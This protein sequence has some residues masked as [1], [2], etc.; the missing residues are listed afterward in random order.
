MLRHKSRWLNLG[1]IIT[2]L[3]PG[4]GSFPARGLAAPA[5]YANRA[6]VMPSPVAPLPPT[7]MPP[8][9]LMPAPARP[10]PLP[11][12]TSILSP[13]IEVAR[14]QAE[15]ET[16]LQKYLDYLGPRYV[17]GPLTVTVD[18]DWALGVAAWRSDAKA[19]GATLQIIGHRQPGGTWQVALP[20]DGEIYNQW[21]LSSTLM[22]LTVPVSETPESI[23]TTLTSPCHTNIPPAPTSWINTPALFSHSAYT[24][25]SDLPLNALPQPTTWIS[26]ETSISQLSVAERRGLLGVPAAVIEWEQAQA[27]SNQ[28]IV[29]RVN[30]YPPAKDWRN[31]NGQDW[32]TPIRSQ[33]GCGSCVAFAT[34]GAIES[35][36]KIAN[37]NSGLNPDLSEAHLFFCNGRQCNLGEPNYGWSPNAALDF[38]RDTGIVDEPC[39]PYTD[40]N[41]SCNLCTDWSNR[42][43]RI[44]SWTGTS[45][46]G[47]MKQALAD[48]GPFE[49][50]MTVYQDFYSY[51]GGIYR[52]T[53]G[54]MEGGHAVTVVGYDESGGYWIVKN[55]W[56]TNWGENGWFRIAYGECGIDDYNYIPYV[57]STPPTDQW[58]VDYFNQ[59]GL[60]FHLQTDYESTMFLNHDWGNGNPGHGVGDDR[61]SIRYERQVYFDTAGVWKFP[62]RTDD[63]FRLFVDGQQ[64]GA[65][66]WDGWHDV[67]PS[68]NLSVG[69]HTVMLEY[70]EQTGTAKVA[71]SWELAPPPPTCNPGADQ[72]AL[73]ADPN[74][75]GNCV[76]LGLGDY[77]N[78]G[79]LGSLGNDNAE[80]IRV[81]SNVK[82]ILYEHDAYQGRAETFTGDDANLNDNYISS[83]TVSSVQVQLRAQVPAAPALNSPANGTW[84]NE[85]D[86]ITLIW[87]A[88]GDEY[89]GE[90]WGGASGFT[91]FGWQDNTSKN[92]GS[93][94]AG[95][96]YS[97]HIKARNGAGESNW[98]NTWSFTVRPAAPSSLSAQTASCSQINLYW[99][100]NSGNEEGYRIYRN[101]VYVAQVGANATYYQDT[102]LSENVS[103]TYYVKSFRGSIESDASN[104]VNVATPLCAP[105]QPDL[106]PSQWPGWQYPVVPSSITGTNEVNSLY[107]SQSTYVDWGLTN[108]GDVNT[109]GNTYAALYIDGV[110]I[111]T[112]NFGDVLAG[113]TWGF[114]DWNLMV[115]E[116]GWHTL[117]SVADPND[118]I[119]ESDETNNTFERLF[120]WAPVAPYSDDMESGANDWTATGLWHQVDASSPHPASH[121]GAHSWWYGQDTNGNYDT[122][123]ANSG[124]LTAPPVYIP[125][126]GYYLRFWYRYETETQSQMWDQRW[127]QLA[128]D[129]GPFENVLQLWND[130]MNFWL[131]SQVI[132]LSAYAGH[133]VQIRFHFDSLD[134]R[135]NGYRGWYIDDFDISDTPPPACSDNYE[136]NNTPTV[137]TAITYGQSLNADICPNGDYDFYRFAGNQGDMVIVDINAASEG[138]LL[139][140]YV[141]LIAGDGTTVLAEHDDEIMGQVQDSLLGYRL[142][143][144]G[145]YYIKVKAWNHPSAGSPEHF[146]V[147]H[148]MTDTVAPSFAEITSP[149]YDSWLSPISVTA[150]AVA[151]DNESGIHRIEFLW[152]DADWENHD[153]IWLGM[154]TDGRDG[155]S[156]LFDTA[157]QPEQDGAA[158]YVWAFDWAGNWTGA[159]SWNLGIDRTP[160]I[161]APSVAPKYGDAPFRDF[162]VRWWN[163][164]DNLSGLAAYDVQ[165][166]D[167]ADGLWTDMIIGTTQVYTG[168]VGD[169]GHT[170]YFRARARD[171]ANNESNYADGAGDAH[172]TVVVCDTP[173]DIYEDD[174]SYST[175]R[176]LTTDAVSQTHTVHNEQDQDWVNFYA[177]AGITYTLATTNTGGHADTVL[178]LYAPDG[179]TLIGFNDD[180]PGMY[181][182]SRL[183]W[184]PDSSGVY[185][186]RVNHWDPWAYGCTTRYGLSIATNDVTSPTGSI[187][188]NEG[189]F[190]ATSQN[191]T[192]TL[193][194]Q[195]EGTGVGQMQIAGTDNLTS[196][197]WITY[198]PT[199][200]WQLAGVE[201]SQTVYARFRDRAG[202]R[203]PIYSATIFLD[204]LSPTGQLIINGGDDYAFS[205]PA[206]LTLAMNDEGSGIADMLL[207]NTADFSGAAWT[208]YTTTVFW[209]LPPGDG[210]RTVYV[211]FRDQ[212]GN[213]AV[214]TDAIL[215]DTLPPTGSIVI[216]ADTA[217]INQVF[218]TLTLAA[219]DAGLGVTHEI[220]ANDNDFRGAEWIPYTSVLSWTLKTKEGT[221]LLIGDGP[222]TVYARFRDGAG[223]VS[224]VYSDTVILDTVPPTGTVVINGGD[225]YA[226]SP[227][228]TLTLSAGDALAGVAEMRFANDGDFF[229]AD[230]I[231]YHPFSTWNLPDS[232]GVQTVYVQFRDRAGNISETSHDEIVVYTPV[233]ANFAAMPLHG[234][235]PL[236][237][238]FTDISTGP[239][240][241]W[242][243]DF[244]DGA[245]SQLQNPQHTFMQPGSYAVSLTVSLAAESV[246][247]PGGTT[248][249]TRDDYILVEKLT[250][251]YLPLVM[252]QNR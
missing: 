15:M 11:V 111:A 13:T 8:A 121:S 31:V 127:I 20:K 142:T 132:D 130:P 175:A 34:A 186:A 238:Q 81:G 201:G 58:K 1:L 110:Q 71:L 109:G 218:V 147:L 2:L 194:V 236:T 7:P 85:G 59:T 129:G 25:T 100:D 144:T 46:D 149:V 75:G 160:P 247:L 78:P 35:R 56:G 105:P 242:A 137:A 117:K 122:G 38:A 150:A 82:A 178:Y 86:Q 226:A 164:Y 87:S 181:P 139:D 232:D 23:T 103:Y 40:H 17:A 74:Y 145:T 235:A 53:W 154:D 141:Y 89:Y 115:E 70:Y 80:S 163:G 210:Q 216:N 90:V 10:L 252:R 42:V 172:Y 191:V 12:P 64:I 166:R 57:T 212:A 52:H 94:W 22:T 211:K 167:G 171:R 98:S 198:T 219:H 177:A 161:V 156:W 106:M 183:D 225:T 207:A 47:A 37:N 99:T 73:Y 202:N 62:V 126:S 39:Y 153:W 173:P 55:S 6:S 148:L 29:N 196:T 30:A 190:Y 197:A 249:L 65:E 102:N 214:Y 120:Y 239:V 83:N 131:S 152:H 9:T 136:P 146:Y 180:Y 88:T 220:L 49:A 199:L 208:P 233:R 43:T 176:W 61:F 158:F 27:A 66:W 19:A 213:T 182:A 108:A 114:F 125:D 72:V 96:T 251:V 69:D 188:I 14:A 118:L 184:Q 101:G 32:T 222:R 67:A 224:Q 104:P 79:A 223:R 204:T 250:Y 215:L 76:T 124:D 170:Y 77:P 231:P 135:F 169:V 227:A 97:W 107:V 187:V 209:S 113:R 240:V 21:A 116:P 48:H 84:F 244:G 133:A 243:W 95:Y 112:Y 119:D 36:L 245:T 248:T 221:L 151:A 24:N 3:L 162:W 179:H 18:G 241:A 92:I 123:A 60:E 54:G 217:Y 229:A 155:W 168:F 44:S 26:G 203:S 157:T 237:V 91:T 5:N 195:D 228:V 189:A 28:V 16:A 165:Y 193:A 246:F 143:Y 4:L 41:Q 45:D 51:S 159:A 93:Q 138:S 230:W 134:E 185:Y 63:G 200:I 33:G 174:D 50:M 128:I 68:V 192:L 206:T 234:A 140:S 205:T